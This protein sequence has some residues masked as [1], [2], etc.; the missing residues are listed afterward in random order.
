MGLGHLNLNHRRIEQNSISLI[1]GTDNIPHLLTA[2]GY[3]FD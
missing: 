1:Y 3:L 2:E